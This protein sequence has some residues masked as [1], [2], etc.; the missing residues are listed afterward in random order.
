MKLTLYRVIF[1]V[2]FREITC[3]MNIMTRSYQLKRRAEKQGRTRQKII[4]A[5]IDLHQTKGLAGTTIR[6][7]AQR[8]KVG[9]V[10]VYRHFPDEEAL[11]DACSGQYFQRHPFPDVEAWRCIQDASQRLRRGLRDTYAYHR[12]TEPM[13]TRILSEARDLPVMGPYHAYWQSAVD[14]IVAA[15]PAAHRK[16]P[17]KAGLALALSFDTWHLLVRRQYLADDQAINLMMRLMGDYPGHE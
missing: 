16:A 1:L 2:K 3:I 9:N 5:A 10:T 12:E 13:M 14:A 8:A 7:I 6:D 11:V 4:D 15:W 17:L